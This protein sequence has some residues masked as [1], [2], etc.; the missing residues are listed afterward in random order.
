VEHYATATRVFSV[1]VRGTS[2]ALHALA[3]SDPEPF[4]HFVQFYE[5]DQPLSDSLASFIGDGLAAGEAGIVVATPEHRADLER[6]L[7]ATGIDLDAARAAGAY[8]ALDADET[9]SR[10]MVDGMPDPQP[11]RSASP[12]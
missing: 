7:R 5:A 6:R 8:V 12:R 4:E 1:H 2:V 11:I 3:M 9:L 10:I